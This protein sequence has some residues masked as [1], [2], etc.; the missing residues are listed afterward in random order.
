M[1]VGRTKRTLK[2]RISEHI[3]N[4]EVGFEYH[5][6]SLHFKKPNNQNLTRLKF[7]GVD[8]IIPNWRGSNTVR[9]ISQLETKWIFLMGTLMPHGMNIELDVNDFISDY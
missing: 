1:Y 3:Y 9:E 8:K 6:V 7:W 4:I 2:K 5:S